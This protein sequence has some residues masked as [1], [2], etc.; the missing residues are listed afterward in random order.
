MP[1]MMP[2]MVP[3]MHPGMNPAQ[4]AQVQLEWGWKDVVRGTSA[5]Q[6]L[7]LLGLLDDTAVLYFSR[8]IKLGDGHELKPSWSLGHYVGLCGNQDQTQA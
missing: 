4:A 2:G 7:R 6:A 1:G 8:K 3:G 5:V